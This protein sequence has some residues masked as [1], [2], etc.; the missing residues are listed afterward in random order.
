M[1]KI[2]SFL[3]FIIFSPYAVCINTARFIS[4][5]KTFLSKSDINVAVQK[6][7]PSALRKVSG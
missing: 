3:I 7:I 5:V 1:K 2:S 6:P 4:L